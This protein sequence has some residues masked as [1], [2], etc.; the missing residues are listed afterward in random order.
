MCRMC[1]RP[2]TISCS[3]D[4][5]RPSMLL[6]LA[7]SL[8][9]NWIVLTQC[10]CSTPQRFLPSYPFYTFSKHVLSKIRR[11]DFPKHAGGVLAVSQSGET[12]V[13]NAHPCL[14]SIMHKSNLLL[15]LILI[16]IIMLIIMLN[17]IICSSSSSS[18][19]SSSCSS[20]S[21][22]SYAHHH[23]HYHHHPGLYSRMFIGRWK[24][25]WK[26]DC[27]VCLLSMWSGVILR[28]QQVVIK[29]STL[30]SLSCIMEIFTLGMGVYLN[31]GREHAVASTK[32]FS[33]Q[34][35]VLALITLW[36]RQNKER[37]EGL[38]ESPLT[39]ELLESLQ[40]LPISFGMGLRTRDKCKW[41][42]WPLDYILLI[43]QQI[44]IIPL[45][46]KLSWIY[47]DHPRQV[48]KGLMHKKSLF[49]LGKGY[50]EPIAYEGALKIKVCTR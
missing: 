22:S 50:G 32:S 9:E 39:R 15:I 33:S 26:Q 35:T 34:V 38:P 45:P 28:E 14:Y 44:C 5:E 43:S 47:F 20:S 37:L 17:I 31:A 46:C 13:E 40:R 7:R 12:K 11:A 29:S 18:L 6:S 42:L 48:A 23:H 49:V 3:L 10:L 21:T 16:I 1:C 30:N 25:G 24:L 19:S 27:P 36:F 41:A 8:W 4:V 2:Y